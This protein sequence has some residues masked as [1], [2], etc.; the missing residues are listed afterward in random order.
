MKKFIDNIITFFLSILMIII[1][2][3]TVYFCLDVFGIIEVPQEYSIAS[4]FYSQIEVIANNG[5]ILTENTFPVKKIRRNKETTTNAEQ[6]VVKDTRDP[7]EVMEEIKAKEKERERENYINVENYYYEQLDYYGRLIYEGLYNNLDK[8]KTGTFTV[9]Y[10]KAFNDLLNEE[11]G[12]ETLKNSFQLAI[13]ALTF[14]NPDL[15][16]IDVT[17]MYLLMERTTRAFSKTYKVSIGAGEEG[18]YLAE[19]FSSEEAVN[20][21]INTVEEIKNAIINGIE[22]DPAKSQIKIVHDYLVDTI[23]YNSDDG[24]NIYN[25]YGALINKRAVCEGYARACKYILDE[26][27]IPCI[28]ACGTGENRSGV[29]ESHAWNYVMLDGQWYALDVTWDDP[30]VPE[31]FRV[32]KESRYAYFLKGSENF[33]E[34]H[35]EDGNIVGEAGFKYPLLSENDYNK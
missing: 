14:D 12:E 24:S 1:S 23:D 21:A 18:S 2:T 6:V 15:F 35:I 27:G 22:N 26:L 9:N 5:E 17:K 33:F 3:G 34:D 11:N 4:L 19:Q 16:Y 13:N 29:T 10:D 8:L 32:S 25:V 20:D 31:N 7:L 30:V 28:I